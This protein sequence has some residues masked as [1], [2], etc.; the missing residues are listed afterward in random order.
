MPAWQRL[1]D[2]KS[3][4]ALSNAPNQILTDVPTDRR[5][6]HPGQAKRSRDRK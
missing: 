4:R 3:E 5:H 1:P 6:R 2:L